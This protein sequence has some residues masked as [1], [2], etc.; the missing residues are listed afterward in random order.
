MWNALD[1]CPGWVYEVRVLKCPGWVYKVR[2]LKGNALRARSSNDWLSLSQM[3]GSRWSYYNEIG[4]TIADWDV[5]YNG[6]G[7]NLRFWLVKSHFLFGENLGSLAILIGRE[8]TWISCAIC[9]N[10]GPFLLYK[11]M[12]LRNHYW[13]GCR[14]LT[15]NDDSNKTVSASPGTRILREKLIVR[16]INNGIYEY[17]LPMMPFR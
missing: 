11:Q 5:Y 15:L 7:T 1:E 9:C 14:W 2:V 10:V 16:V 13:L 4:R 6:L 3:I 8:I 12:I 17:T